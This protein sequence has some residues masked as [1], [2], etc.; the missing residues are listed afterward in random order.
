MYA[1]KMSSEQCP[2]RDLR[3]WVKKTMMLQH[4]FLFFF[5]VLLMA[6]RFTN[7]VFVLWR[8]STVLS[9]KCSWIKEIRLCLPL[10]C[11]VPC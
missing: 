3:K 6:R 7:A 4:I 11:L 1:L 5:S 8:V 9:K 2:P 10:P